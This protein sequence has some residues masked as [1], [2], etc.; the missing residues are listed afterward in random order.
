MATTEPEKLP[1][2]I[3]SR[4][5][6]FKLA[7][8]TNSVITKHLENILTQENVKYD[9]TSLDVIAENASGS[10]RDSLSIAEQCISFCNVNLEITKI[11]S[12]LG[13]VDKMNNYHL[14]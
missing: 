1:D 4:C 5:L 13:E 3:L 9:S 11:N 10:I 12:F 8:A 7:S 2:T 6:H 14:L